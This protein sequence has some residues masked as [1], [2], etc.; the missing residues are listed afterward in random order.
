LIVRELILNAPERAGRAMNKWNEFAAVANLVRDIENEI[1]HRLPNGPDLVRYEMIRIGHRQFPWQVRPNARLIASYYKLYS[2]PR[3][4]NLVHEA[5]GMTALELYQIV[6]TLSGHFIEQPLIREP[7]SN[8][9]NGVDPKTVA[10]FV[11]RYALPLPALREQMSATQVYNINW[12]YLFDPL[13][14]WPM[15]DIGEGT[16]FCPMPTLLFWR[17][18]DGIYFDLVQHRELFDQNFGLAFQD[19]VSDVVR[20]ADDTRHLQVLPEQR[21]GTRQQPRDS[22]DLIVQDE[23]AAVFVECKASR[24]KAQAKVDIHNTA[25]IDAELERL[26]GFVVQVYST[27]A[28]ALEGGYPHWQRDDR[29]VYPMV[30]TLDEWLPSGRMLN[31]TLEALVKAGLARRGLS[32][33]L[34]DQY[35]FTLCSLHDF[36][37]AAKAMA[38][39]GVQAVLG[40]KTAGEQRT[41]AMMPFLTERFRPQLRDAG[42]LF[43]REWEE[44]TEGIQ[45]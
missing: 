16:L 2:N 11:R 43:E 8:Q 9:V 36:E 33:G 35:P 42:L 6:L 29:L 17:L 34:S 30:V 20:A 5:F 19:V 7:V 44:L 4:A 21:Y 41:W 24:L 10:R 27:M 15:I 22:V 38:K 3:L 1:W 18:T 13:R 32:P 12:A 37:A 40:E 45:R 31:E 26:A 39:A 25:A 23:T 14:T 28:D